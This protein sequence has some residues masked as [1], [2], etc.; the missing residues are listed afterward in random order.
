VVSLLAM[1]KAAKLP[2]GSEWLHFE[3]LASC[4]SWQISSAANG[5]P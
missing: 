3:K 1:T 4:R 2:R 5:A